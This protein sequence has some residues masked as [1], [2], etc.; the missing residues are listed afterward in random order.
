ME[1]QKKRDHDSIF[2]A[3]FEAE[4][5]GIGPRN[6]F[7]VKEKHIYANFI[8]FSLFIIP[9]EQWITKLYT[10]QCWVSQPRDFVTMVL[11]KACFLTDLFVCS[12]A[13]E[14]HRW[15]Q[16]CEEA[17]INLAIWTKELTNIFESMWK[18]RSWNLKKCPFI[19]CVF[20]CDQVFKIVDQ[21][22]CFANLEQDGGTKIKSIYINNNAISSYS[23]DSLTIKTNKREITQTLI[24]LSAEFLKAEGDKMV[25]GIPAKGPT[26]ESTWELL[27]K[28]LKKALLLTPCI[29]TADVG[30]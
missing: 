14:R 13:V 12:K 7:K 11:C 16:N 8:L 4:A 17:A 29:N 20:N 26:V 23:N 10:P 2:E 5:L 22:P 25:G 6:P 24:D 1:K 15:F 19:I 3:S 27:T 21:L 28:K 9:L 18:Y 30:L